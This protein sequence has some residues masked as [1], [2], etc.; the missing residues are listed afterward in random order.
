MRIGKIFIT[1]SAGIAVSIVVFTITSVIIFS[2]FDYLPGYNMFRSQGFIEWGV[3]SAVAF[4]I[5][6]TLPATSNFSAM[7]IWVVYYMHIFSWIMLGANYIGIEGNFDVLMKVMYAISIGAMF[8]IVANLT[9][10]NNV[11]LVLLKFHIK[12]LLLIFTIAIMTFMVILTIKTGANIRIPTYS[13]IYHQRALYKSLL[14]NMSGGS[15]ISRLIL[16]A[17]YTLIP[18][19][20]ATSSYLIQIKRYIPAAMAIASLSVGSSLLV[21][22]LAAFKSTI[23]LAALSFTIPI[24]LHNIRRLAA[25]PITKLFW[26]LA[27]VGSVSIVVYLVNPNSRLLLHYFRR[28]FIVPGMNVWFYIELFPVYPPQPV[29]NAPLIVSQVIYGTNGSANSGLIGSGFALGGAIGV[30]INLIIFGAWLSVSKWYARYVPVEILSP[31][32]LIY[33]YLFANSATTTVL[34]SYGAILAPIILAILSSSLKHIERS[35]VN[36]MQN[37]QRRKCNKEG[38]L[39]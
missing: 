32:A 12:Y 11:K 8:S 4:F 35:S 39:P 13:E 26:L 19:S 27:I 10:R 17:T 6:I 37:S 1:K 5:G 34:F 18:F 36:S 22:S 24:V 28:I 20:L 9:S 29:R 33:G 38:N 15:I 2:K 7:I 16:I 30:L 14:A 3:F 23:A 25:R 21:F 31:I